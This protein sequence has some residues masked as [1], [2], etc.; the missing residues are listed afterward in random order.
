MSNLKIPSCIGQFDKKEKES[1]RKELN[2]LKNDPEIILKKIKNVPA[3]EYFYSLGK[4]QYTTGILKTLETKLK[5][6]F[7]RIL[8][9]IFRENIT[10]TINRKT[11][12][13]DE[14]VH[15][16]SQI[17]KKKKETMVFYGAFF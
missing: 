12:N 8:S 1:I 2:L 17:L 4:T 15:V 11:V 13:A 14:V 16:A 10:L 3:E 6:F 5:F 9:F 7:S